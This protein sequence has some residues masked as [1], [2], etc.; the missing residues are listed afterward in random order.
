MRLSTGTQT[1]SAKKCNVSIGIQC[2]SDSIYDDI[3]S[4]YENEE[5][6]DRNDDT[7]DAYNPFEDLS[8][9]HAADCFL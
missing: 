9:S 2:D 3:F 7:D 1:Q 8:Q 5:T 4:D 6:Y